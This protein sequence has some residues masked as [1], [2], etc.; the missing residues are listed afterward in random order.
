MNKEWEK[1]TEILDFAFQPI[2]NLE[3]GVVYGVEVLLRNYEEAG[4]D[5]IMKVFDRAFEEGILYSLDLKLKTKALN[6]FKRIPF[7]QDIKIFYNLDNRILEMKDY[8]IGNTE[9]LLLQNNMDKYSI[10]YELSEKLYIN[11]IAN[12]NNM[13]SIYSERGF[14]VAID[15]FST[16]FSNIYK[17][18][19]NKI[20]IFKINSYFI[21]EIDE[22]PK[23]QGFVEGIIK[24]VHSCGGLVVAEGI[25]TLEEYKLCKK[26]GCDLA[27]GYYIAYPTKNIDKLQEKYV[28]HKEESPEIKGEKELIEENIYI[29]PQVEIT[30]KIEKVLK[31]LKEDKKRHIIPVVDREKFIGIIKENEIKNY[32]LSPFGQE[33]L[34]KKEL[35]ELVNKTPVIDINSSIAQLM[36]A[37]DEENEIDS[38]II[39][40]KEK[41]RGVFNKNDLI[42]LI[43]NEKIA[44]FNKMNAE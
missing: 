27:Q 10:I 14:R 42:N 5:S 20:D 38:L 6:K 44:A 15:N 41:Y 29:I 3:S 8:S 37:F 17:L 39:L 2:I 21:H 24:L 16:V 43:N 1:I 9:N 19:T 23:K 33:L 34:K 13:I 28:I 36:K 31:L 12:L 25:E 22:S 40:E 18:F 32:L 35:T 7:S 30:D 26:L 11:D 4:F